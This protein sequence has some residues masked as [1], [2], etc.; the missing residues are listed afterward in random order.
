MSSKLGEMNQL[1]YRRKTMK[2]LLMRFQNNISAAHWI[3]WKSFRKEHQNLEIAGCVINEYGEVKK[4]VS[5]ALRDFLLFICWPCAFAMNDT[6][7]L[8][9]MTVSAKDDLANQKRHN[10]FRIKI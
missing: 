7:R 6:H 4:I 2:Y 10:D 8:M 9:L 5:T 1:D 3:F